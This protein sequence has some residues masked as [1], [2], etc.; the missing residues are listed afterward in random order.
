MDV[1]QIWQEYKQ[2][3]QRFLHSRVSNAADAEDLLQEILIKT[4]QQLHTVQD[5]EKLR[6]WL[7]QVTR[8][9]VIDYYR[10]SHRKQPVPLDFMMEEGSEPSEQARQELSDCVRPFLEQLPETYKAAVEAVDL[11]GISQKGLAKDLGL[12]HSAVKSRV[13]RGR[14]MLASL[15][16]ECCRYELDVRGNIIDYQRNDECC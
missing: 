8:N 9:T 3:L 15:F 10:Q 14:K 6:A 5:Q 1:K 12:S 2:Q 11:N 7:F 13:Q 4:Y 16:Q